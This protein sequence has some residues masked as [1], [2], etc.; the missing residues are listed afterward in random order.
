MKAIKY[1]SCIVLFFLQPI[2]AQNFWQPTN[3]PYGGATVNDFLQ[4]NDSTIFLA[5]TEGL[6]KSTDNGNSWTRI[7]S[8][9]VTCLG[10]DKLNTLYFGIS[11]HL[12]RSTDGG[13][14]W[15]DITVWGA[16]I[17]DFVISYK[18]TIFVGSWDAWIT[19]QSENSDLEK[20]TLTNGV[21]RS[22]DYGNTW[23]LVNSGIQYPG[24]YEL[25]ILSNNS[26]L[27]GT[28]GGGVYK[29]TNWGDSWISSNNGIPANSQGYRYAESFIEFAPGKLLTGTHFSIYYSSN[30]G[31]SWLYKGVGYNNNI[32]TCFEI[33]EFGTIY[34]GSDLG[35]GV[36]YSTNNGTNWNYLGLYAS[37]KT[38]GWAS[39]NSLYAGCL[40]NGLYRFNFVDSSWIQVY[41][42]GYATVEV[43]NILLT[44]SG[45]LI[46]KTHSWGYQ[47][48]TDSGENW[49][50]IITP[51]LFN[52]YAT[53]N[54]SIF[55]GGY[56]E[57]YISNDTGKTWNVTSNLSI[58]SLYFEPNTQILY[59][60]TRTNCA[61]HTS[62]NFGQSWTLLY[63]FP[64]SG[65]AQSIIG[66]CVTSENQVILAN[67]YI[68]SPIGVLYRLHQST[69]H[70]QSWQILYQSSIIPVT[71]MLEDEYFFLYALAY[72]KLFVSSDEGQTWIIKNIPGSRVLAADHSGRVFFDLRYSTDQGS[73][74]F[75]VPNS[76]FQGAF[77]DA[78]AINQHNKIYAASTSGIFYGEA[79]SL[80]VS[81]ENIKPVKSFSL[82]QNYPNP[83][84]P[85]TVISYQLP[86][87]G[88]VMLK[89][90]DILGN[91]IA[92]LVNEEK[93]PGIYEVE[94]DASSGIRD[95]VSGIYFY[96]LKAGN[97]TETKKMVLI[98]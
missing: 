14:S 69:D 34:A 98:K 82:S 21:F 58:S 64:P 12:K 51:T 61:I 39:E 46:A 50:K 55:I 31:D 76:G 49:T 63:H 20:A 40:S 83:F 74:W 7:N 56:D 13:N 72:N 17:K 65:L 36:F 45:N 88:M 4:Y 52:V 25:I 28:S 79:D 27:V 29:S 59:L 96:Q 5:T 81:V 62:S 57:L 37:V 41:N 71:S 70:G 19:D 77:N 23:S 30:Y 9:N 89:V 91:E 84:N 93:Q 6:I 85:S 11:G 75:A 73:T 95:L 1:F 60:G 44:K 90:Y 38:L 2:S 35:D 16:A 97:Y 18:D 54:D 24:V 67:E 86:V 87:S 32:A 92:T 66:L 8:L 22:F 53:I 15:T 42:K 68:G 78:I 33:D 80:V 3:G 43:D 47:Y 48:T 10:K 94:F 26:I